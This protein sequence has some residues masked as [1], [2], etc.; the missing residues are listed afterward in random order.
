M[1]NKMT[2]EQE[3]TTLTSIA[4]ELIDNIN[5][6]VD[7]LPDEIWDG[8]YHDILIQLQNLSSDMEDRRYEIDTEIEI[9]KWNND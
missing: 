7:N 1:D 4:D 2:I 6:F 9:Y 8:K 5:N 3:I